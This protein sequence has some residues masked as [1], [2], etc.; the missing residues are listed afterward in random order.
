MKNITPHTG[1][2]NNSPET[3]DPDSK[4][5]YFLSDQD[6][7]FKYVA[8]YEL[9]TGQRDVAEK[10]AWDVTSISVSRKG[11]YRVVTTNQD[12][13]TGTK[14]IEHAT[15]RSLA[16]VAGEVSDVRISERENT[17]AG[18]QRGPEPPAD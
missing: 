13:R 18:C 15:N 12:A 2:I 7:E 10:A 16:V 9:A 11:K 1:N 3:F 4:Y 5:L 6:S 8:R 17:M 14:I